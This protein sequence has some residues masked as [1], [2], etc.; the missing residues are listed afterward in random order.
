M[1]EPIV[2]EEKE[3]V[4]P[5]E[6]VKLTREMLKTEEYWKSVG[7]TRVNGV[8]QNI[9]QKFR[10]LSLDEFMEIYTT[11]SPADFKEGIAILTKP[12]E[13]MKLLRSTD[14]TSK[15]S[16]KNTMEMLNQLAAKM[17]I[18]PDLSVNDIKSAKGMIGFNI[19]MEV[20]TRAFAGVS[21]E[22]TLKKV[23]TMTRGL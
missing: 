11:V 17:T 7:S 18:D 19:I 9:Y 2:K 3:E 5:F 20:F 14:R 22:E 21:F 10:D 1:T 13:A 6:G 16:R 8:N 23:S 4:L 15:S 12:K